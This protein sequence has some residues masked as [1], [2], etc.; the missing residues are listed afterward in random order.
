MLHLHSSLGPRRKQYP[1]M[2]GQA[3]SVMQTQLLWTYVRKLPTEVTQESFAA[4]ICWPEPR[5]LSTPAAQESGEQFHL[6]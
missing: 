5:I 1:A 6:P 3:P 4:F 2:G